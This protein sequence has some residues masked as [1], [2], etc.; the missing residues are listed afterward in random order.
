MPCELHKVEKDEVYVYMIT[1]D[2]DVRGLGVGSKLLD[3]SEDIARQ[4]SCN[5]MSLHV[6][7]GNK[8]IGLYERKGYVAKPE[9]IFQLPLTFLFVSLLLGLY[10]RPSNSTPYWNY[11]RSIF[12]VKKI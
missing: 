7:G 2:P 5:K 10:T 8:A 4:R 6:L 11:G 12:M 1:V 9:S 3:W